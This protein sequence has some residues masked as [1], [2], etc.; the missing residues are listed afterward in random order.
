MFVF[1]FQKAQFSYKIVSFFFSKIKLFTWH[2]A[3]R[4]CVHNVRFYLVQHKYVLCNN[5]NCLF[6][7]GKEIR[8]CWGYS[9]SLGCSR[10]HTCN[11]R[12]YVYVQR[13]YI[14]FYECWCYSLN[15]KKFIHSVTPFQQ[16][17]SSIIHLGIV[18]TACYSIILYYFQCFKPFHLTRLKCFTWILV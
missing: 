13:V 4:T 10:L 5:K 8:L 18:Y 1:G 7:C 15:A 9:C 6:L 17:W 16:Y 14:N 3:L 11:T 2:L 12:P